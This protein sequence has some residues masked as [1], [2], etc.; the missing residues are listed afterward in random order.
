M[1]RDYSS[2]SSECLATTRL[3]HLPLSEPGRLVDQIGSRRA[4]PTTARQTSR[5]GVLRAADQTPGLTAA[6]LQQQT[7]DVTSAAADLQQETTDVLSAA[8]DLQQ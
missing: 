1:S 7:T 4:S 5:D 2:S 6:D 8:A 3:P